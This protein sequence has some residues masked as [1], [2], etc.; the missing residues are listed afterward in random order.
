MR[1]WKYSLGSVAVAAL[2]LAPLGC[3]NGD[4]DSGSPG[5]ESGIGEGDP[6]LGATGGELASC[7]DV[8]AFEDA[9]TCS[10][11]GEVTTCGLAL[12]GCYKYFASACSEGELCAEG[13]CIIEEI[14]VDPFEGV[15]NGV[16]A[17]GA[18]CPIPEPW[19]HTPGENMINIAFTD[20]NS[21]PVTLWDSACGA[22]VNWVYFTYGW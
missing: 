13:E 14:E 7:Q 12:D 11:D 21:A 18:V 15:V 10:V 8:C 4:S 1:N 3:D 5:E 6:N 20:Q 9:P 17:P 19:G 2:L 22:S 16:P